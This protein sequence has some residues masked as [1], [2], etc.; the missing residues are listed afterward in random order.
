MKR[1]FA[2]I[3]MLILMAAVSANAGAA[4]EPDTDYSQIMIEAAASG[5]YQRG[6]Q[7]EQ[8]RNEKIDAI[9]SDA[10]KVSFDE[11][12]LLSKIMYAE[13][14]SN[15]LSD[16]WKMCVGEVVLNRAASPEFP[17]TI[18]GVLA[19]PG[20][21][22]GPNSRYFNNLR[23]SE[24]C[25][26]LALRLM[27]GE[28]VMND[29]SVVFQA[30]FRQGSGTHTACYDRYLGW[31]YFCISS[32][33]ELYKETIEVDNEVEVDEPEIE[34]PTGETDESIEDA[35]I[36]TLPEIEIGPAGDPAE[37]SPEEAGGTQAPEE[38]KTEKDYTDYI[39][40]YKY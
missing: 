39:L 12:M 10:E 8:M 33:P 35:G 16:E 5:D 17:D 11:L 26:S 36:V 20:Q 14:G 22:Y 21:Y 38:V 3:P 30:N 23:P 19:Q 18:A 15:W 37:T 27:N 13:A 32:R 25:A 34:T 29:P 4:Y 40:D 2:V 1:L 6:R 7:A 24:R 31:T 9:G 28:R